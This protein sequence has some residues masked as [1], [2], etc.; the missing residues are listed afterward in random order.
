MYPTAAFSRAI[1]SGPSSGYA[2]ASF[3]LM[4]TTATPFAWY[5]R[6]SFASSSRTCLT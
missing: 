6:A 5:S 3:A 1:A 4:P 2:V